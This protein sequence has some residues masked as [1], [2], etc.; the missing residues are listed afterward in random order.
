ME[1]SAR[2]LGEQYNLT[3]EEMNEL[4]KLN[5]F[6]EGD[7]GCYQVTD[8][9]EPYATERYERCGRGGYDFRT[10]DDSVVDALDTTPEIIREARENV[11]ERRKARRLANTKAE[12][13]IVPCLDEDEETDEY[14]S[15]N[16]EDLVTALTEVAILGAIIA[17]I[18]AAPHI[19]K[20]VNKKIKPSCERVW[21]K[22][23][24]KSYKESDASKALGNHATKALDL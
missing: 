24:K 3:A 11:S 5:G 6:L 2:I 18:V 21:C 10:W 4:F 7:P 15:P 17:S 22:I 23:T 13:E 14:E 12:T 20:L 9:G 1:K 8:A 19:K 16:H